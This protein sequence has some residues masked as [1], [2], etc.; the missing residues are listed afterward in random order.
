MTLQLFLNVILTG[1]TEMPHLASLALNGY[2]NLGLFGMWP[3]EHVLSRPKIS[4]SA[5]AHAAD[6]FQIDQS[7]GKLRLFIC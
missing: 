4:I 3:G 6:L 7:L 2:A 1:I 5:N